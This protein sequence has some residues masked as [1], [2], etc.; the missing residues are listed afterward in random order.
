M[1]SSEINAQIQRLLVRER[2]RNVMT[3]SKRLELRERLRRAAAMD[4]AAAMGSWRRRA[5]GL[6]VLRPAMA[7]AILILCGG[8][9]AALVGSV[10]RLYSMLAGTSRT[11]EPLR[12]RPKR[13][14]APAPRTAAPPD[15]GPALREEIALIARARKDLSQGHRQAAAKWLALHARRFPA[16][17]LIEEREGLAVMVLWERGAEA[18]AREAARRFRLRYPQSPMNKPIGELLGE[19]P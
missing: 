2:N 10:P 15:V 14:V 1:S 13:V 19:V 6:L 9:A 11:E 7:F 8:V 5:W 17:A 18:R 4:D 3:D 16:G 12:A